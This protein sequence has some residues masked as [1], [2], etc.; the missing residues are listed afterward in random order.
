VPNRNP[1]EFAQKTDFKWFNDPYITHMKLLD[2]ID[3]YGSKGVMPVVLSRAIC[4][5]VGKGA[6]EQSTPVYGANVRHALM[7]DF[8][9][10]DVETGLRTDVLDMSLA[11]TIL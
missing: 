11:F 5:I 9:D 4:R 1:T 3:E 8:Q 10:S 2:T 6:R 7:M